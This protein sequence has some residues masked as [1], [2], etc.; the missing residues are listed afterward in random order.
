MQLTPT[1]WRTANKTTLLTRFQKCN[2]DKCVTNLKY[3]RL[4]ISYLNILLTAIQVS[5]IIS[6][7]YQ[8]LFLYWSQRFFSP[9]F[10]MYCISFCPNKHIHTYTNPKCQIMQY[11]PH[12]VGAPNSVNFY[13]SC[14]GALVFRIVCNFE[15][16]QITILN[17]FP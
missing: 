17:K 11:I 5:C 14:Q 16:K 15:K 8:S 3:R 7:R 4:A 1:K 6:E 12:F 9:N 13:I 2:N 10:T